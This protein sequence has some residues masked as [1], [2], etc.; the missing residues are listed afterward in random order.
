MYCTLY[1]CVCTFISCIG[2]YGFV[3]LLYAVDLFVFGMFSA[4]KCIVVKKTLHYFGGCS[5]HSANGILR[6]LLLNISYNCAE[7]YMMHQ[8]ASK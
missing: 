3:F 8:K 7:Q 4:L 5:H 6:I 2:T 1:I